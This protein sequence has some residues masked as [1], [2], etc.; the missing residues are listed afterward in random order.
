LDERL[1]EERIREFSAQL[2]ARIE[3]ALVRW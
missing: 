1:E 3:S 2:R